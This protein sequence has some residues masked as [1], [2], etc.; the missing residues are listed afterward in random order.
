MLER[1][2]DETSPR[3]AKVPDV[4]EAL[5]YADVTRVA[6]RDASHG[7]FL[8]HVSFGHTPHHSRIY[9]ASSRI[10]RRFLEATLEEEDDAARALAT[11]TGPPDDPFFTVTRDAAVGPVP[12]EE[13]LYRLAETDPLAAMEAYRDATRTVP[14]SALFREAVLRRAAVFAPSAADSA[15]IMRIVEDAYPPDSAPPPG[16]LGGARPGFLAVSVS[17]LEAATA[18]YRDMLG[19]VAVREVTSADGAMTARVLRAGPVV[20]ELI[21]HR[22]NR[23]VTDVLDTGAHRFQLQGI[24][25]AG[26]FVADIEALY[27]HLESRDVAMDARIGSDPELRLRS[28]VFRDPDGNRIQVFQRAPPLRTDIGDIGP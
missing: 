8:S 13:E 16:P 19:L 17:D 15:T 27:E 24:V 2:A 14:G 5:P 23:A 9:A 25:K 26:L 11:L 6:F 28:F 21:H 1:A 3:Y 12:S 20:V 7:D 18:W 4:V 10:I 22:S